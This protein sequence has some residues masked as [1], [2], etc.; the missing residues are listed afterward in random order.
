MR[1]NRLHKIENI[2][3]TI[4]VTFASLVIILSI[5]SLIFSSCLGIKVIDKGRG[6]MI[7][8]QQVD[9]KVIYRKVDYHGKY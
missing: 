8:K 1:N 9:G 2:S 3:F 7:I 6:Y 4:T 5:L